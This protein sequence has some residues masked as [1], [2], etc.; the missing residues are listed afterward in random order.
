MLAR[1]S[2]EAGEI[3]RAFTSAANNC[4]ALRVGRAQVEIDGD[5]GVER[6]AVQNARQNV[7]GVAASP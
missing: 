5:A 1:R 3:L 6:D 4:T 2:T 7:S